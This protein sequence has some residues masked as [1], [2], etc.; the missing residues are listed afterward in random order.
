[1]SVAGPGGLA[2]RRIAQLISAVEDGRTEELAEVRKRYWSNGTSWVVGVTGPAGAGKST[3]IDVLITALRSEGMTVGVL[4]VDPSS[5][6]T[7]G[8]LLGDRVRMTRHLLDPGV[9]TRSI[10][11]RGHMG[12]LGVVVPEAIQIL[13]A[14]GYDVVL[15]ETIGVGQDEVEVAECVHTVVLVTAPGLGDEIQEA[16]AGVMEIADIVVLNKADRLP[17]WAMRPSGRTRC[18]ITPRIPTR[19]SNGAS[20]R[21]VPQRAAAWTSWSRRSIATGRTL[22][23]AAGLK[24]SNGRNCGDCWTE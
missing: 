1:M 14:A 17:S 23:G 4:A 19:R 12:G 2:K 8:A 18:A 15:V 22:S 16:K 6:A 9:F 21:P 13:D 5:R 7:G 24:R 11:T 3:L 20:S 10:A